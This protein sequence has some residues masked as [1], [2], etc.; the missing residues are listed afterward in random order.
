M[1]VKFTNAEISKLLKE[2]AAAYE[3]TNE[4]RFKIRAYQNAATSIEHATSEAKDLWEEGK[5]KDIPGVGDSLAGHLDEYFKTGKV[6]HFEQVLKPLPQGMFGIL[7][8]QGIG[9]KTAF[10]LAKEF[11][12]EKRDTAVEEL[13]KAAEGGKISQLEGF[14]EQSEKEIL[15]VLEK[16]KPGKEI[17]KRLPL[18]AATEIADRYLDYLKKND[19]VLQIEPLGSLRRRVST[20]GDIDFAIATTKPEDVIPYFL[21]YKEVAEVLNEGDVKASVL[22]SNGTR[23]DLMTEEPSGFGS[24]L[25]HFTGSK[26]HNIALR[27]HA[28]EIGKSLS[29]HGIKYKGKIQKFADEESFYKFIGLEYIEPEIREDAGEIDLSLGGKLPNLVKLTDIKGELHSHT[30]FSDGASSL[31]QMVDSAKEKG[32]EYVGISDHAPSVMNRGEQKVDSIVTETKKEIEQLNYS[33]KGIRVLFGYEINILAGATL[34]LPDKFIKELD[35]AI[36]SI[37]TS[38]NQDKAQITKRFLSAINNPYITIIGHPTGRLIGSRESYDADW[39]EIFK[40][41]LEKEKIIEIN[42]QPDRLDLPDMLVREAVKKGVKLIVNTDSHSLE[43]FSL[44]RYGIDVARRGFAEKKNIVN[45]LSLKDF[46]KEIE[47]KI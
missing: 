45:T 19:S 30:T 21:S 37:H 38:F 20:I 31:K 3:V 23:V 33:D 22:L 41:A 5:L 47:R 9:S 44:M 10:K 15:E 25:Q 36:A 1:E 17:R 28:L 26:A 14:G 46:L 43:Q 13:K 16:L 18:P 6:K 7:G 11:K 24:L 34:A 40:Q 42:S 35:Y 27:K 8:L 12:L 2:V 29:E 32:Y 4:D 39:E